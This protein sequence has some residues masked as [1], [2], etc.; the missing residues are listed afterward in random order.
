MEKNY[1]YIL[2][3][4]IPFIDYLNDG[5]RSESESPQREAR[6][7]GKDS[8]EKPRYFR[9]DS[10]EEPQQQQPINIEEIDEQ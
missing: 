5:F 8:T 7:G 9:N 2:G 10:A 6:V 1:K 3:K 4:P